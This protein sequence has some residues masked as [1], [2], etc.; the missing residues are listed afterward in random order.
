MDS[1]N[2]I[3]TDTK[4]DIIDIIENIYSL[5]NKYHNLDLVK[6]N[7]SPNSNIITHIYSDGEITEQ[8]GGFAYLQRNERI[9]K[10]PISNIDN[11]NFKILKLDLDITKFPKIK[12]NGSRSKFGYAIV[13][14]KHAYEIRNEMLKLL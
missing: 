7:D 10:C 14:E 2:S 12:D 11:G 5:V 3:N 9:I 1:T 8:K 13:L 4:Q 6:P